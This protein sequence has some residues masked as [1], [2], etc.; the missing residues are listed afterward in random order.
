MFIFSPFGTSSGNLNLRSL[1]SLQ[2][3][4]GQHEIKVTENQ[5]K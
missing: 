1:K 5:Q 4:I 2:R 3:T